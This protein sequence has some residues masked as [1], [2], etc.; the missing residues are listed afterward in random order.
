M[1]PEITKTC[2]HTQR[3]LLVRR[4][5]AALRRFHHGGS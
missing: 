2:E 3:R 5:E 4:I 1:L